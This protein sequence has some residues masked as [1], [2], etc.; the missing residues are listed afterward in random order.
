M[1]LDGYFETGLYFRLPNGPLSTDP[2]SS[3]NHATGPSTPNDEGT[4]RLA[5]VLATAIAAHAE[6]GFKPLFDGKSFNG[7]TGMRGN[8]LPTQSW[9]IEDGMIRTQGDRSGGDLRTIDDIE[10]NR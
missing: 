7:W 2:R 1:S 5:I 3:S 10:Q 6:D 9:T 4:R 8:P